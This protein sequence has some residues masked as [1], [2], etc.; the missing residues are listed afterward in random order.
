MDKWIQ[1]GI[2][3]LLFPGSIIN[4]LLRKGEYQPPVG[5]LVH[6]PR[7]TFHVIEKGKGPITVVMDAGLSGNSLHWHK[8]QD[9]TK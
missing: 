6:T 8:V 1:Y 7:G 5:K 2:T 3:T 4:S 9:R